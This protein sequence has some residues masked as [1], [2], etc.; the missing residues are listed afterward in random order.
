MGDGRYPR[1]AVKGGNNK[2]RHVRVCWGRVE[3]VE[4]GVYWGTRGTRG[5]KGVEFFLPGSP[6]YLQLVCGER[7][8]SYHRLFLHDIIL[9]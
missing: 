6:L 5:H 4:C 1:G 9:K 2:W 7:E 8:H 3:G